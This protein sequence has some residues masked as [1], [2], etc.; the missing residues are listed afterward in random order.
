[1]TLDLKVGSTATS[2]P[3]FLSESLVAERLRQATQRRST[4]F[5]ADETAGIRDQESTS[6]ATFRVLHIAESFAGGVGNAILDYVGSLPEFEHHLVY[7][8]RDDS[9]IARSVLDTFSSAVAMGS[10]HATRFRTVREALRSQEWDVVHAH[11]SYAGV[12]ARVANHGSRSRV[13]YTPHCYASE[14]RD[15]SSIKRAIFRFVERSLTLRTGVFAAC[16]EREAALS[17]GWPRRAVV[18]VPNIAAAGDFDRERPFDRSRPLHIVGAGRDAVQKDPDFF[19]KCVQTL[20]SRGV[21]VRATWVG[22][23]D[24]LRE[25]FEPEGIT[26]TGWIARDAALRILSD[27]DLYV[28]TAAWEGF[29]VAILEAA[30][31]GIPLLARKIPAY[32]GL[33]IPQFDDPDDLAAIVS[34]LRSPSDMCNLVQRTRSAL[35]QNTCD[36]QRAALLEAYRFASGHT[37]PSIAAVAATTR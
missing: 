9:P 15:V 5:P 19:L 24:A 17:T 36:R 33:D 8:E 37:L 14:R 27:G 12:Y 11:S 2:S 32:A 16:S 35:A 23:S 25:R 29:P 22:G 3:D 13:V 28:H 4:T 34:G 6:T 10:S 31:V 1:M 30:A 21:S 7:G 18:Y 20:R 26:V